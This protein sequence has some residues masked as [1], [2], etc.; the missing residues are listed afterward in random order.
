MC[1]NRMVD[2]VS[3]EHLIEHVK[4]MVR[5]VLLI[6]ATLKDQWVN[7]LNV[8]LLPGSALFSCASDNSFT[9]R[10]G[11]HRG[12]F[13]LSDKLERAKDFSELFI[14]SRVTQ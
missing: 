6:S 5:V 8:S 9:I 4:T 10:T 3:S 7:V 13:V 11:I 1:L 2:Y 12:N 14:K